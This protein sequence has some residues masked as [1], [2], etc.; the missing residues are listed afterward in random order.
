MEADLAWILQKGVVLVVDHVVK[1]SDLTLGIRSVKAACVAASIE[2]G[3]QVTRGW[4]ASGALG[5]SNPKAMARSVE[6]IQATIRAF[7]ELNFMSYLRLGELGLADLH[8]LS[9]DDEDFASNDGVKGA[10]LARPC[11]C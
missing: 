3:K 8:Q 10:A 1:S 11:Q 4:P 5:L 2:S 9:S 6:V 7:S